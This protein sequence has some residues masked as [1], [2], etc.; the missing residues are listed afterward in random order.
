MDV[1]VQ[2]N[3]NEVD[4][5]M[6]V[7]N[8]MAVEIVNSLATRRIEGNTIN[9]ADVYFVLSRALQQVSFLNLLE[10]DSYK[11]NRQK[12]QSEKMLV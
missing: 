9:V 7:L 2:K 8:E 3:L 10:I 5:R 4:K 6:T 11:Q 1:R 12:N